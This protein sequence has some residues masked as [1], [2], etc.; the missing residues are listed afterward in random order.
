M[1][2]SISPGLGS[3]WDHTLCTHADNPHV[4]THCMALKPTLTCEN[5]YC[6]GL[7]AKW[8]V[9]TDEP[10]INCHRHRSTAG[11]RAGFL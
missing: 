8:F 6:P 3:V 4:R 5:A 10:P 9:S 7:G 1:S 11:V 2:T